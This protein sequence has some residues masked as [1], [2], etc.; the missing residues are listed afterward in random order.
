MLGWAASR[1]NSRNIA[2]RRDFF[3]HREA[4][5]FAVPFFGFSLRRSRS[6]CGGVVL[7]E[8]IQLVCDRSEL[9]QFEFR[10]ADGADDIRNGDRFTEF[11]AHLN[12]FVEQQAAVNGVVGRAVEGGGREIE[13]GDQRAELI[14][15]HVRQHFTRQFAGV[16][17]GSFGCLAPVRFNGGFNELEV[18]GRIVCHQRE[19]AA[20]GCEFVQFVF[21]FGC[22]RHH[23]IGYAVYARGPAGNRY[24]RVD[25]SFK[26]FAGFAA[27][28]FNRAEFNDAVLSG[29]DSRCFRVKCNKVHTATVTGLNLNMKAL[30]LFLT[31]GGSAAGASGVG[32]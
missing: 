15:D 24:P 5:R 25:Q 31:A 10:F 18:E 20:E 16:Q 28:E 27:N 1:A 17:H 4:P 19:V 22:V 9:R 2:E 11:V 8:K 3:V 30:N 6:V 29:F 12:Q 26:S 14:V 32:G 7:S 13:V 23:V 21:N